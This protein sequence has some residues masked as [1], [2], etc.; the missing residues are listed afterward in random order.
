M[1][2]IFEQFSKVRVMVVGDV[3]LDQYWW[4]NV[5]RIS[6][7][8]PVPVVN[9]SKKTRVA[10]GA[11]NVAVNIRSL[12]AEPLLFGL[13]GDDREGS[14]LIQTLEEKGIS[15]DYL[16]I[17]ESQQTITKTRIIGNNQQI[18]RVDQEIYTELTQNTEDLIFEKIKRQLGSVDTIVI[19]DYAKGLLTKS[20]LKRLITE[21]AQKQI[22]TIVDP[23]GKNFSKYKNATLLTPNQKEALEATEFESADDQTIAKAGRKIIKQCDLEALVITRSEKGMMLFEKNKKQKKLKAVARNVFDVTGAG[24]T[25]IATLAV[26]IGAGAT[27]YDAALLANKAA[28]FVVE[29]IGTSVIE[30]EKLIK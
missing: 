16:Y 6:P 13:L 18:T 29:E 21:A 2:D 9:L 25:V 15:S 1:K 4:G 17:K 24:D 12:G 3:M 19:S 30:L 26:A 5:S 22:I 20:L 28:G 7:E 23:K 14:I 10:G 8:A 11:A 27:F